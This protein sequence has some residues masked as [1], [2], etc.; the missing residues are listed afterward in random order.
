MS[1]SSRL[2]QL[3]IALDDY[4]GWQDRPDAERYRQIHTRLGRLVLRPEQIR[5]HQ[6]PL[7]VFH[8]IP[9]TG[10]ETMEYLLAKNVKP[11][12]VL[13]INQSHLERN[14]Y[15]YFKRGY[16][17]RLVMGHHTLASPL[18]WLIDEPFIH[19]ALVR[20]PVARVVS[21]Y[22]HGRRKPGHPDRG[23]YASLDAMLDDP[24]AVEAR[25]GQCWRWLG[26]DRVRGD[27]SEALGQQALALARDLYT[28]VGLTERFD[29]VRDRW[30]DWL[31]FDERD[32]VARNRTL[33]HERSPIPSAAIERAAALNRA[34]SHL[35][36][37][38]GGV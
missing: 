17:P 26:A 24:Q 29:E 4:F 19:L 34:D 33:D 15:A 16:G 38:L 12:N 10:G 20:E 5:N 22:H 7:I 18:Y 35:F 36:R 31:G 37:G 27:D 9:K 1:E 8:H 32:Y 30:F 6:R 13:H 3:P 23:R 25:N 28:D 2:V 21:Y 14:P 11:N